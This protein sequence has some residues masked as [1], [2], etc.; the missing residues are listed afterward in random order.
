MSEFETYLALTRV[1]E[2]NKALYLLR[3]LRSVAYEQV[4]KA[5]RPSDTL[6]D[7]GKL[8]D[9]LNLNFGPSENRML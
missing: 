6:A 5:Q 3:K 2:S 9:A 4:S 1:H 8:K 7:Y